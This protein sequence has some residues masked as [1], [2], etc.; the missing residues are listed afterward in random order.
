[1]VGD[2]INDAP[3]PWPPPISASRLGDGQPRS[4]DTAD[5]VILAI[6]SKAVVE[7]LALARDHD[8]Q[9]APEPGPGRSVTT[10]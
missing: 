6:V 3:L 4:P 9:G 8:G 1:M 7:A 5:L 10:W 2:G